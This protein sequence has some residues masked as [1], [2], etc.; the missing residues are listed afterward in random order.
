MQYDNRGLVGYTWSI[1]KI[2]VVDLCEVWAYISTCEVMWKYVFFLCMLGDHVDYG[3]ML[4]Y[5]ILGWYIAV[6]TSLYESVMVALM[7]IC[8]V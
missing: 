7:M 2:Y 1:M 8:S 4:I 5:V 6:P 3:Y